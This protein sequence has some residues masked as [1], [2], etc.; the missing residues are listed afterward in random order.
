MRRDNMRRQLEMKEMREKE[1]SER[2]EWKDGLFK[3]VLEAGLKKDGVG[4]EGEENEGDVSMGTGEEKKDADGK[5]TPPTEEMSKVSVSGDT[6]EESN[7]EKEI[8][9]H[10]GM[11]VD[12]ITLLCRLN[13]RRLYGRLKYYK[14]LARDEAVER[15]RHRAECAAKG[16]VLREPSI[17]EMYDIDL[18]QQRTMERIY[19]KNMT[20]MQLAQKEWNELIEM[21]DYR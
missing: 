1:M 8:L 7:K 15:E 17:I 4:V 12:P 6:K 11:R 20:V 5:N 16:I 21:A 3:N 18:K 13:T 19:P 9:P 10:L 14:Q 2:K